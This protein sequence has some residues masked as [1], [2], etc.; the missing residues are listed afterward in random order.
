MRVVTVSGVGQL[1]PDGAS[2]VTWTTHRR[3]MS[4]RGKTPTLISHAKQMMTPFVPHV[5]RPP[6]RHRRA[7]SIRILGD[8]FGFSMLR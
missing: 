2:R 4:L 8:V 3:S 7:H 6:V 1:S 5:R